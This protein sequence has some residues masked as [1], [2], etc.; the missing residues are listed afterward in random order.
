[1]TIKNLFTY[2]NIHFKLYT[3]TLNRL[4]ELSLITTMFF[5]VRVLLSLY[6][7]AVSSHWLNRIQLD[8]DWF[9]KLKT[10]I[11]VCTGRNVS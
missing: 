11:V 2:L 4:K 1:M 3:Y 10:S 8:S 6:T 7:V 5:L 9:K